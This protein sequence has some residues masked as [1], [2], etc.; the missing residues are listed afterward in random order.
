MRISLNT[1]TALVAA[2]ETEAQ[3]VIKDWLGS[4]YAYDARILWCRDTDTL[5][6]IPRNPCHGDSACYDLQPVQSSTRQTIRP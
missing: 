2:G 4:I 3:A 6:V 1:L 5:S